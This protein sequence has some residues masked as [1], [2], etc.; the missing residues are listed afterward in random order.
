MK[1]IAFLFLLI[2]LSAWS[3]EEHCEQIAIDIPTQA[4]LKTMKTVSE[5]L[6]KD[7]ATLKVN[8]DGEGKL[9]VYFE[10]GEPKILKLTYKNGKGTVI[11]QATFDDLEKGTPLIYENSDIKGKAIVLEKAAS[12]KNGKKYNFKFSVRSKVDPETLTSYP[13]SFE[14]NP[15]APVVSNGGSVFSKIVLSP[16][17]SFFSWDGTFK[18]VEFK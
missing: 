9:S 8:M 13:V 16:G 5:G 15:D 12:F 11:K 17:V 10:N 7:I 2:S 14:A 18:K 4:L 3:Q 1:L 6:Y